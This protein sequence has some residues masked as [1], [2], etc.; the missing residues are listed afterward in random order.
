MVTFDLFR[1][2][3]RECIL[4]VW[5]VGAGETVLGEVQ[6]ERRL[7]SL[8]SAARDCCVTEELLEP[9]LI[10]AG[11]LTQGDPRFS[12][13]RVFN[14]QEHAALLAE[15]PSLVSLRTLKREIVA[16]RT[17]LARL[18][19]EGLLTPRL[20]N[21]AVRLRWS[22]AQA[23]DLLASLQ[24]KARPLSP[25]EPGWEPLLIA[26]HRGRQSLAVLLNA[27]RDGTLSLGAAGSDFSDLRLC[28]A[29]VDRL[30]RPSDVPDAETLITASAFGISV[31][32]KDKGRFGALID[33]GHTP[34]TTLRNPKTGIANV[35]V[36]VTDIADFHRRF[37]TMRT[38]SAET[39]RAIPD[40]RAD[41]K[42]AGVAVFSPDG[43]DFGRLFLREEVEAALERAKERKI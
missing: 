18:V 38:L 6:P 17:E 5:P 25:S 24:A 29:E 11:A 43:Q 7:H 26:S 42:R 21:E 16:S 32:I 41:L 28:T 10:E 22:L 34:A 3:L 15:I 19:S 31:G 4:S 20:Q 2:L 9:F 37:V 23:K 40:L 12:N 36:T 13:R 1:R 14:A 30:A 35:F 39:G 27:A 8:Y 33:A